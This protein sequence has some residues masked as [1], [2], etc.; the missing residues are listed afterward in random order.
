MNLLLEK[1]RIEF[2]RVEKLVN[3]AKIEKKNNEFII[4]KN[5]K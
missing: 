2:A 1:I 4:R 3:M 5:F